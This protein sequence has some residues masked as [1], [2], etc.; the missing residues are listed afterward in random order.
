[1][2]SLARG[3]NRSENVDRKQ[4]KKLTG[5]D[6]WQN[7]TLGN[8]DVSKELV[9]FLV[10]ADGELKMTWDDTGLLVVTSSVSSQLENF[11]CKV[12]EDSSEVNWSTSTDTLS[13]VSLAEKTVHTTDWESQTGLG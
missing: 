13:I 6:V 12:F 4:P 11:S 10:V 5:M 1:M 9:Q 3:L 7:T 2:S 8:G